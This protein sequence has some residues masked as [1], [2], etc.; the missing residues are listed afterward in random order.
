MIYK[1]S[2]NCDLLLKENEEK[3]FTRSS[4]KVKFDIDF[5]SITRVQN[6]PLYRGVTLWNSLSEHAQKSGLKY[7]F[8]GA[9]KCY[10]NSVNN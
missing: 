3:T 10:T 2:K 9:I 6:S 5:T 7:V 1:R 4:T 8:K